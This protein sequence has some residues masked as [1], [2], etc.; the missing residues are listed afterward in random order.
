MRKSITYLQSAHRLSLASPPLPITGR[1]IEEIAGTVPD[2]IVESFSQRLGIEI[3]HKELMETDTSQCARSFE[4]VRTHVRTLIKEAW[5]IAQL[6]SQVSKI[7][8][9]T[10]WSHFLQLHDKIMLHPILT[11]SQKSKCALAFAEADKALNDGGDEE[12]WLLEVAVR[13]WKAVAQ[14]NCIS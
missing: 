7:L 9:G 3:I 11:S 5:G 12:L 2:D 4:E 13:I 6:L 1:D 14:I 8:S 10:P